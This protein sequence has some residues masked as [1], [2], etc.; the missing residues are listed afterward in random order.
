MGDNQQLST[1]SRRQMLKLLGAGGAVVAGAPL[2]NVCSSSNKTATPPSTTAATAG[3]SLPSSAAVADIANFI[4]P[5]DAAHAARGVNY[6]MGS[7]LA[8]SGAGSFYGQT[9][10][11][12]VN[13]AVKHIAALGGPNLQVSYKD[14]KSGDPT[15]G[16]N[17]V[18]ELGTAN[19][20][21]MLASYVD[22][23]GAMFSG[24]AQYKLLSLDGGGGTGLFGNGKPF[25][26]GMRANTPT[27][28]FPG[29]ARYVK[30]K[31]P[32]VKKITLVAWNLGT[33]DAPIIADFKQQL[34]NVGLQPGAVVL[35][36]VGATDYSTPI[37]QV[38]SDNPDLVFVSLYGLDPGYF[39]KQYATSGIDVPVIGYEL[40]PDA[41]KV[42]GSAYDKYTYAFD[43]FDAANPP[44]GWSK[45]FV[46]EY[47]KAYGSAP[48]FYAAN[49]YEDTFAVWDLIRRVSASGGDI[50]S[51]SALQNALEANPT[52]KSVYGGNATTAG[53]LA[54]DPSTHT[55]RERPMGLFAY[56]GGQNKPLAFFDIGG[57]GYRLA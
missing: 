47:Q 40:T 37:Q 24:S 49:Y 23:L 39:M 4:G 43:Y 48:D 54:L 41:A 8:L 12:G 13:L 45:I 10:T 30:Q 16:A 32:K 14:H 57:A 7:V 6:P 42:A 3:S 1:V 38:K 21:I 11:K 53:T 36:T 25:F 26:W 5:I 22:D 35:T 31:M 27:D 29:V 19:T 52:F 34:K 56:N 18:R 33:E 15:A 51:G 9:M 55:P 50:N 17:A 44:S 28:P 2:L 46:D 20:P